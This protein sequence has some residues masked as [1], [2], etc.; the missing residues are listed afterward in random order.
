MEYK[1]SI[2]SLLT[3]VQLSQQEWTRAL[4]SA[5]AYL[6]FARLHQLDS[7]S[8]THQK[9]FFTVLTY[10]MEAFCELGRI[11]NAYES[12]QE[13][14]GVVEYAEKAQVQARSTA[15]QRKCEA[16]QN[17]GKATSNK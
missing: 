12:M 9:T 6:D 16:T 2:F 4:L 1:S 8:P 17:R 7:H 11:T 5:D 15:S 3:Y 10:R 13:A 14:A